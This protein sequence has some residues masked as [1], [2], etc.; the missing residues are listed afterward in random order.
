MK[1]KKSKGCFENFKGQAQ[2]SKRRERKKNYRLVFHTLLLEIGGLQRRF[3]H[4]PRSHRLVFERT[5]TR[6]SNS[7]DTTHTKNL[8]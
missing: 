3:E 2:K 1:K 7:V 6:C 4:Y 8:F 5:L